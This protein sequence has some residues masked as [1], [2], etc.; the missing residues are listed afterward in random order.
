MGSHT[1]TCRVARRG[2]HYCRSSAGVVPRSINFSAASARN[3]MLRPIRT[4]SISRL[5]HF[6]LAAE[7]F[8]PMA[9]GKLLD[10]IHIKCNA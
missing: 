3:R 1:G 9:S 10:A 6:C 4:D 5:H 8:H 2:L 7:G